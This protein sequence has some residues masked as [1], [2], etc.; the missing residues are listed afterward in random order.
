M[1]GEV[2]LL[3]RNVKIVGEATND[4]WGGNVLT[5]DRMEFD[6]SFRVATT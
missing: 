1:R 5:M 6:G 4:K 3:T 2:R